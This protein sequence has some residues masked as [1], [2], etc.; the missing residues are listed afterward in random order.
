MLLVSEDKRSANRTVEPARPRPPEH[1]VKDMRHASASP[2]VRELHFHE[3]M[4]ILYRQRRMILVVAVLGT[5]LA[6]VVGLLVPPKYTATAAIMVDLQQLVTG[7]RALSPTDESPIDTQVAMLTSRDHLDR[8]LDSLWL[9]PAFGSTVRRKRHE[10]LGAD[11]NR[12]GEAPPQP[13]IAER[14]TDPMMTDVGSLSLG[15]LS[16]RLKM[17]I[18]VLDTVVRRPVLSVEQLVRDLNVMQERRSRI[19]TVKF[20]STSPG[21]AAAIANRIVQLH[22]DSQIEQK[23]AF[24]TQELARI[25]DRIAELKK[26]VEGA[27][28]SAR[29]L[30]DQQFGF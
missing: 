18:G 3:L 19:V 2:I 6:A 12:M 22:V 7:G 9:D 5:V 1:D 17:W 4:G 11:T 14:S 8:V 25:G 13:D 28:V 24:M 26:E 15:E 21:Q 29:T 23:R 27:Q 30:L 16:R 10:S 20:T